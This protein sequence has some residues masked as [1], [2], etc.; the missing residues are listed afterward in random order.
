MDAQHDPTYEPQ[1]LDGL[2]DAIIDKARHE[3]QALQD[4]MSVQIPPGVL[5]GGGRPDRMGEQA[6]RPQPVGMQQGPAQAVTPPLMPGTTVELGQKLPLTPDEHSQALGQA[7]GLRAPG[8]LAPS[9]AVSPP[10]SPAQQF[11]QDIGAGFVGAAKDLIAA[12]EAFGL[13]GANAPAGEALEAART[14]LGALEQSLTPD[15]PTVVDRFAQAIGSMAFSLLPG[16]SAGAIVRRAVGVAQALGK[17]AGWTGAAVSAATEAAQEMGDVYDTLS[18]LVGEEEAQ[19][20]AQEVF[21]KNLAL[22]TLSNKLGIFSDVGR[23]ITRLFAGAVGEGIQEV[24]QY[25]IARREFYVPSD[26]PSAETLKQIGWTEHDGV[27]AQPFQFKDAVEAGLIGAVLGG[28]AAA[29]T[30]A[31]LAQEGGTDSPEVA[32][33]VLYLGHRS[34]GFLG[35]MLGNQRGAIIFPEGF[36][37]KPGEQTLSGETPSA[38]PAPPTPHEGLAHQAFGV[39]PEQDLVQVGARQE[40]G[41][42][43]GLMPGALLTLQDGRQVKTAATQEAATP[44]EIAL[45]AGGTVQTSEVRSFINQGSKGFIEIPV[46]QQGQQPPLTAGMGTQAPQQPAQQPAL[47]APEQIPVVGRTL[48]EAQGMPFLDKNTVA[49]LRTFLRNSENDAMVI[50]GKPLEINY[51]HIQTDEGVKQVLAAVSDI[52]ADEIA[53]VRAPLTLEE[54]RQQARDMGMTMQEFLELPREQLVSRKKAL[55]GREMVVA[56][57]RQVKIGTEMFKQ[58]RLAGK[59]YLRLFATHA[60]VHVQFAR[61]ANEAGGA[62]STFNADVEGD[63]SSLR[64]FEQIMDYLG[65]SYTPEGL[66]ALIDAVPTEEQLQLFFDQ[67]PKATAKQMLLEAWYGAMF[68]GT[69]LFKNVFG[70]AMMLG[71]GYLLRAVAARL[72]GKPIGIEEAMRRTVVA[73]Q[74]GL[75]LDERI[76]GMADREALF[77]RD[78]VNGEANAFAAGVWN[79]IGEAWQAAALA[80]KLGAQ[81]IGEGKL[82]A[83]ATGVPQRLPSGQIVRQPAITGENVRALGMAGRVLAAGPLGSVWDGMGMLLRAVSRGLIATDEFSKVLNKRGELSALAWRKAVTDSVSGAQTTE[84]VMDMMQEFI[85]R[86][87]PAADRLA[88]ARAAEGTLTRPLQD[89]GAFGRMA[90]GLD[91]AANYSMLW[92]FFAPFVRIATNSVYWNMERFPLIAPFLK[93]YREDVRM[94]GARADMARAKLTTGMMSALWFA[95]LAWHG[96]LRGGGGEE[97]EERALRETTGEKA[98]TFVVPGTSIQIPFKPVEPFGQ[99]IATMTDWTEAVKQAGDDPTELSDLS[100]ILLAG[101]VAFSKNIFNQSWTQGLSELTELFFDRTNPEER[102]NKFRRFVTR[103]GRMPVPSVVRQI[104]SMFDPEIAEVQNALDALKA[105]I[106]GVKKEPELDFWAEPRKVSTSGL[107]LEA[108]NPFTPSIDKSLT[109][110]HPT[111]ENIRQALTSKDLDKLRVWVAEEILAA[112]IPVSRPSPVLLAKQRGGQPQ[113]EPVRLRPDALNRLR[114]LFA[115]EIKDG[116]GRSLPEALGALIVSERYLKGTDGPNGS[117]SLLVRGM[118]QQFKDVAEARFLQENDKP[119][120]PFAAVVTKYKDAEKARKGYRHGQPVRIGQP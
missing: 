113:D 15:D 22:V 6:Q 42:I 4:G 9:Q 90:Q 82:P 23:G 26:H 119:D 64:G 57:A 108:F 70:N 112:Q 88:D 51:A 7:A 32:P 83:A 87:P 40:G 60:A 114:T 37:V 18:S 10:M 24:M 76:A 43:V 41:S 75:S 99:F 116:S 8:T 11:A 50:E 89:L 39:A 34:G 33:L 2:R 115:K 67:M 71:E 105:G 17:A 47:F 92:R 118:V 20:R 111:V 103:L 62:L 49:G 55:L 96:F 58:G 44:G 19:A 56:S 30:G 80:F 73:E 109:Y 52:Y 86:P 102:E 25:D 74:A 66:S 117:R 28:S 84:Q 12:P 93:N 45:A 53:K 5:T 38:Q 31:A 95:G 106:P 61:L 21:G 36:P 68:S 85:N 69:T 27:I 77:Q 63:I 14:T 81:Q 1:M 94:G 110:G 72:P 107:G 54:T 104:E 16:L 65:G 97:R 29:L 35:G 46:F 48:G 98:Y 100:H 78:V 79:S 59:D 120:A 101:V 13:I 3:V 91:D